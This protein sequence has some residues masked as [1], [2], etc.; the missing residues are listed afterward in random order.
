MILPEPL[1]LRLTVVPFRLPPRAI[2]PLLP[3][4]DRANEPDEASAVVVVIELLSLTDKLLKVA[5]PEAR[6]NAPVFVTVALPVVFNVKLGVAVA[7]LPIL[8]EPEVRA[9]EVEPVKVPAD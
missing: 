6:L 9:T 3:V 5:P 7:I 2:L 8:P 4:V 1:A